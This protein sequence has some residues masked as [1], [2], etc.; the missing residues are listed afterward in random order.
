MAEDGKPKKKRG[1]KG[2]I[3]HRPGRGHR[4][5]SQPQQKK[6]FRRKA[7]K[8]RVAKEALA[9]KLWQEWDKLTQEQR[10]LLGPKGEPTVPRPKNED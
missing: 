4:R 6:R 5:T 1:P 7:R 9:R 10:D 2:G 3:K 8:E